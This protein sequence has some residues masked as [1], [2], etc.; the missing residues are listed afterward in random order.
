[1]RYSLSR[2]SFQEEEVKQYWARGNYK[3]ERRLRAIGITVFVII[4]NRL[5]KMNASASKTALI[6]I[7]FHTE[8][9][10]VKRY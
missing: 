2:V 7:P 1:M 6:E 3:A 9:K 4:K 5:P 8:E 10:K